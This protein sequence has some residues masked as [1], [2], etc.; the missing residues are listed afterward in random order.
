M[1]ITIT[2]NYSIS[3]PAF[4]WHTEQ[5]EQ[6]THLKCCQDKI[7]K[8]IHSNYG[9]L[10]SV[11]PLV[12]GQV[13][14]LTRLISVIFNRSRLHSESSSTTAAHVLRGLVET[15]GLGA[16][17]VLIDGIFYFLKNKKQKRLTNEPSLETSCHE[18]TVKNS[19][20]KGQS[21]RQK[22]TPSIEKKT[23]I[24]DKKPDSLTAS[25]RKRKFIPVKK[26]ST[27]FSNPYGISSW[28]D[29]KNCLARYSP[30]LA[31]YEGFFSNFPS[32]EP[33]EEPPAFK[34][35]DQKGDFLKE[36]RKASDT[37]KQIVKTIFAEK[38][39]GSIDYVSP[40]SLHTPSFY[41]VTIDP[42][43]FQ[44]NL[45]F[46]WKPT[47]GVQQDIIQDGTREENNSVVYGA[48]SQFN[49]CEAVDREVI[50]F[51]N[52]VSNY[53]HD[54]TQGPQAQLAFSEDQV[55]LINAGGHLGFNGLSKMLD[56]DT[57]T[58]HVH[59]YFTP[60]QSIA[61]K[62][63]DQLK[64]RGHLI[65]Y[66]AVS[67]IPKNANA[68]K[69]VDMVLVA[70]PAFGIYDFFD[71]CEEEQKSEIQFLFAL[72]SFRAQFNYC[73]QKAKERNHPVIFKPAAT[74]L[75][76]FEN[77]IEAVAKAY[78]QAATEFDKQLK[79]HNVTVEF[80]SFYTCSNAEQ[81]KQHLTS[82]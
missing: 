38:I 12:A 78:Y 8:M 15:F 59:G 23:T 56:A 1:E 40:P 68:K 25:S 32:Q 54:P 26:D 28:N 73:I 58:Y 51:G 52:A 41:E 65:E 63:I 61:A 2:S 19:D 47:Q 7:E 18:K 31:I 4:G 9:K 48:A 29:L 55:E 72:H 37:A 53:K 66:T 70:A 82:F 22:S 74:G 76:V 77:K 49:G 34:D 57:I 44:K 80:Q 36:I 5:T 33:I 21:S 62:V 27:H 79:E 20:R 13:I 3:F 60:K 11:C 67:S 45:T 17:C 50:P 69:P 75:G 71:D 39:Q 64:T 46:S 43:F 30:I 35:P 42:Q 81:L 6:S 10:F 14:G 16:L 24:E